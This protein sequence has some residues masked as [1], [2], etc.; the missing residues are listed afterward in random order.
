M[1]YL[2]LYQQ[3]KMSHLSVILASPQVNLWAMLVS[4]RR[5]M[6]G[7]VPFATQ[8]IQESYGPS[9]GFPDGT[10]GEEKVKVKVA[11]LCLTLCDLMDYTVHGNL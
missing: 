4:S 9:Q 10:S 7:I 1:E 8:R 6:Q 3:T 2:L 5:E 11:Q